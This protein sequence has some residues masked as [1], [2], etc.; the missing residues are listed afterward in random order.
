MR[1]VKK[2]I[3]TSNRKRRGVAT[4]DYILVLGIIMPLAFIVV[5]TG[6]RMIR[7]VYDLMTVMIAWPFM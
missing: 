2:T 3:P 7:A 5:P 6:M 1:L 4:L